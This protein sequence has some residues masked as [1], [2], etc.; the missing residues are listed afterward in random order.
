MTLNYN[1]TGEDRKRLVETMAK[2]LDCEPRYQ[3][4][5]TFGYD[6]DYF[7]ID[8]TGTVTF[9]DNADS[10][11]VENLVEQLKEAGF[12]AEG[13]EAE[14]SGSEEE[15]EMTEI[16]VVVPTTDLTAPQLR[17]IVYLAHA[18]QYL[19]NKVFGQESWSID[20]DLIQRLSDDSPGEVSDFLDVVGAFSDTCRGIKFGDGQVTLTYP[21]QENADKN[22]ALNTL[23][24]NMVKAAAE[25]KRVNPQTVVEENEK[26]YLRSWLL[27]VGFAGAEGKQGRTALLEGL[28]GHTAFRTPADE[29]KWKAARA[30]ARAAQQAAQEAAP[31]PT[32]APELVPPTKE[33]QLAE[34][35]AD[36]ALIHEVN[37]AFAE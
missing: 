11:E 3:G 10:E 12:T 28:K 14:R 6:V 13:Y 9:D 24:A 31:E 20:D 34:A 22:M 37:T 4:V 30:A 27:R 26:Y 8:R 7:H 1:V 32:D 21:I 25:A 33:E 29:A 17:N 15:N 18:K 35:V 23:M 19:L 2:I 16:N 36:A 5:P